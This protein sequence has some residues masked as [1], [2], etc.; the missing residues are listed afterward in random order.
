MNDGRFLPGWVSGRQAL[1]DLP[2]I[3][4]VG[5]GVYMNLGELAGTEKCVRRHSN[6]RPGLLKPITH[7][8]AVCCTVRGSAK[9][10]EARSAV[11]GEDCNCSKTG[12]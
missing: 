12:V 9:T 2:R 4:Q 6:A 11:S 7:V 3:A 5:E 1:P 10:F 8:S